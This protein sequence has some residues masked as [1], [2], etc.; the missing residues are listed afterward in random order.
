MREPPRAEVERADNLG[1]FKSI[2]A[3]LQ[4]LYHA[5]DPLECLLNVLHRVAQDHRPAVG[6][7]HRAFGFG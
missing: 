7:G 2:F 4:R 6:T 1:H 3:D 5:L